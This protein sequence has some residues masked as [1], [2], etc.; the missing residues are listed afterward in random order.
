MY[1]RLR[2]AALGVVLA[3]VA[4]PLVSA[5][6]APQSVIGTWKQN[7]AKSKYIQ[8]PAAP[9]SSDTR[10][11]AVPGGGA[12]FTVDGVDAAGKAT[13]NEIVTMFDG[14]EADYKGAAAP[15][16]RA[17]SRIDDRTVQYVT[18]VNG[19]VTTTTRMT[20]SADGKTRTN[21]QTGTGADGKPV[22]STAVYERQ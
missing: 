1:S 16:T 3:V 13:H 8:G 9:K 18:R 15:T 2:I 20:I 21:V 19:R 22:N 12:K 6:Q 17:Y 4:F 11:E 5:A 7:M 10:I 14:K